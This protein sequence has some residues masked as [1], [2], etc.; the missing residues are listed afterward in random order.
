MRADIKQIVSRVSLGSFIS[1]ESYLNFS[2]SINVIVG[3]HHAGSFRC[4]ASIESNNGEKMMS[5][6]SSERFP[7][8]EQAQT[9][10]LDWAKAWIDNSRV[11]F[12]S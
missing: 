6:I 12:R 1:L 7:S 5:M 9:F 4:Q 2:I 8:H 3:V 11:A 10:G